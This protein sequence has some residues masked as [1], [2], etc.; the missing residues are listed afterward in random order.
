[1]APLSSGRAGTRDG[2]RKRKRVLLRL[3]P[4]IGGTGDPF[5]TRIGDSRVGRGQACIHASCRSRREAP[6]VRRTCPQTCPRTYLR[7][8]LDLRPNR[9][10]DRARGG[11]TRRTSPATPAERPRCRRSAAR[12]AKWPTGPACHASLRNVLICSG[13]PTHA[14]KA[15]ACDTGSYLRACS[16]HLR[17]SGE[18]K[19]RSPWSL[20]HWASCLA[21]SSRK[22]A[23]WTAVVPVPVVAKRLMWAMI[24]ARSSRWA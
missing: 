6:V 15:R 13:F 16:M 14:L 4:R 5:I 23:A 17:W 19:A 1:M 3:A 8:S 24:S 10:L 18:S 2:T 11:G 12:Q 21:T 22:R 7:V 9:T 20:A